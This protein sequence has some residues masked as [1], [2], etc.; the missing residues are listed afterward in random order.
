MGATP[1]DRPRSTG[2]AAH[3]SRLR[4]K[5][6][7]KLSDI[8]ACAKILEGRTDRYGGA[9]RGM[10]MELV[11]ER[12]GYDKVD[13]YAPSYGSVDAQ[14][15]AARYPERIHA[16]VIDA[17]FEVDD[18]AMSYW[19]GPGYP[20]ALIKIVA[21]QCKRSATALRSIPIRRVSRW[22]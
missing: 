10:D 8:R 15:Y 20:D 11:R 14:A 22:P 2:L 18:A 3:L 17:G 1:S 19:L 12:L 4:P 21:R 13:W 7:R 6:E 9:D 16:L 5:F